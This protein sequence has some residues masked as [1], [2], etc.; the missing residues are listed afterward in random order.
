MVTTFIIALTLILNQV[1]LRS[2]C[3]NLDIS[4]V[5]SEKV[6]IGFGSDSE[7]KTLRL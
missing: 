4:K 2:H 1:E 6:S 5:L 7:Q 3:G